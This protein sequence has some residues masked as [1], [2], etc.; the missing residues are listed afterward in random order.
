MEFRFISSVNEVDRATWNFLWNT[1]YPFV[2]HEFITAL[3]DTGCTT[4]ASGWQPHHL[5]ITKLNKIVGLVPIYIKTHSFGEY[6]FDWAWADAYQRHEVDYY[7]KLV[8]AIPFTPTTG[9]RIALAATLRLADVLPQIVAAIKEECERI[10]AS[11][12]H[13]LFPHLSLSKEL[14]TLECKQ[15]LGTQFHWLNENYKNVEDFLSHFTSRKR[16]NLNRER[17]RVR[18]QGLRLVT[19]DGADITEEEWKRFYYFY[20]YTY[21]KRSGR[22]GY[23]CEEFF[24]N[25]ARTIPV[26]ILMVQAYDGDSMVAASLFFRSRDTL[27]G[28][29]WGCAREYD[30][31]HFEACYYQGIEYAIE[32]KLQRFDP[33]AQG[34]HKIQRGF[35]PIPTWSNHWIVRPEFR[36]AI[37]DFLIR[38]RDATWEYMKEAEDLLPFK[39]AETRKI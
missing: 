15:R 6:V 34:E 10:K 1:D 26:H 24:L 21:V 8:S 23:L 36:N 32:H 16:K 7:P 27:Y 39:R 38:E 20:H 13:C 17:A 5:T 14:H 12:W 19:K 29:Y 28:R 18:E 4:A 22:P 37:N 11:S 35:T 33:G 9:P 2:Q 25:I 30:F 31:L 3:E